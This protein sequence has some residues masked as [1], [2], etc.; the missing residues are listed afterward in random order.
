MSV[1]YVWT[2]IARN[3]FLKHLSN[4]LAV[5]ALVIENIPW[6]S[7]HV[8]SVEGDGSFVVEGMQLL[9]PTV[10]A[11]REEMP[12]IYC[13]PQMMAMQ[14]ANLMSA[15]RKSLCLLYAEISTVRRKE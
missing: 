10:V 13:S 8:C 6:Y 15:S 11:S 9:L 4:Y 14:N 1:Y 7:P 2:T 3:V 12:Q 5:A